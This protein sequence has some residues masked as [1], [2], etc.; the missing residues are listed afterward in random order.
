MKDRVY[1]PGKRCAVTGAHL[2]NRRDWSPV[3]NTRGDRRGNRSH[4]DRRDEPKAQSLGLKAFQEQT[5]KVLV[6][7]LKKL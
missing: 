7:V 5:S 4:G 6:L 3:V 1:I 2:H